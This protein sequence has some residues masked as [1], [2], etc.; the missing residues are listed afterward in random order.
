MKKRMSNRWQ[1]MDELQNDLRLWLLIDDTGQGQSLQVDKHVLGR[2]L[3]LH[4]RDLR[5]VDPEVPIPYPSAILIRDNA[6]VVKLESVGL[7]IT[8]HKVYVTS[9]PDEDDF[10]TWTRPST[11]NPFVRSLM[12]RLQMAHSRLQEFGALQESTSLLDSV[13]FQLQA[14]EAALYIV[15]QQL[16]TEVDE[17]VASGAQP[18]TNMVSSIS[19]DALEAVRQLKTEMEELMIRVKA[20]KNELEEILDDDQD[21]ADM[22]LN[23]NAKTPATSEASEADEIDPAA[24]ALLK[25][26]PHRT[27]H[28]HDIEE[29][30][31]LLEIYLMRMEYMWSLLVNLQDR[32]DDCEDLI[33][34]ELDSRRNELVAVNMF[35]SALTAS[36][37]FVSMIGSIFG[38]NLDPLPIE[39]TQTAF[40]ASTFGSTAAAIVLFAC[41]ML[42]CWHQRLLFIPRVS[43]ALRPAFRADQSI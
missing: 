20:I 2:Q 30:E 37:G 6:L 40:W 1:A 15:T 39:S 7:I 32:I 24:D 10:V 27:A 35:V 36:F 14:L 18:L 5:A 34:I 25:G 29:A 3:H 43:V 42:Y 26:Q 31:N 23:K 28:P 4:F 13:P 38:Q 22:Y 41:V 8:R 19:R 16:G 33:N 11:S 12:H 9:A 21:M 17:L